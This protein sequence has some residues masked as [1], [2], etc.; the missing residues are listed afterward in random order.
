MSARASHLQLLA[1]YRCDRERA[2]ENLA[3]PGTSY[4]V[5]CH[6]NHRGPY[7]GA[8]SLLRQLVPEVY[9]RYPEHVQEHSI[10]ILSLAPELKSLIPATSETLTSLAVPEERTRFYS[11]YRTL[12]LTHGLIDFLKGCLRLGIYDHLSLYFDNLQ[13]ADQLD[14]EFLKELLRRADPLTL[15]VVVGTSTEALPEPFATVLTTY[16][17][18][19]SV[20]P[21]DR[22]S[23]TRKLQADG[24]PQVWQ[25]WLLQHSRGYLGE[26]EAAKT[27]LDLLPDS[28]PAGETF[29]EGIRSL[30]VQASDEQRTCWSQA[31]IASN[32][33]SDV[34]LERLAYELAADP[35]RRRWHD[36]RAEIL[37][38]QDDWSLRLGA[39]PYQREHGTSPQ[40]KGAEAL[41]LA[42][43][44][45]LNMGYYEATI[46][47]G[48]RGRAVI[49]WQAQFQ[50]YWTFTTKSTTSLAALERPEEAEE[51]YEE[52]RAQSAEP[53]VHMNAAYAL[54]MF[55]TRH[56]TENKRD[57]IL[58]KAWINEAI[59]IAS[60]LPDPKDSAFHV[61][62][63]QNGLALIENHLRR[64][65]EALRLVSEGMERL[66]RVLST[67]EH[68]LHRSVLL[69]NRAQVYAAMGKLDQ[70][71]ADYTAV[72]E[73][74][75]RYSEYYFDRGNILRRL[76]R[77][78]EALADYQL[79]IRYSPPYPEA[80]YNRACLLSVLGYEEE[81]LADYSYVIEIEPT[82]L[83][84]LINRA[85]ML[86]ERGLYAEARQDIANGLEL[87]PENAQLLCTLGL[88]E[89]AEEQY[90][91]ALQALSQ[92][93]VS[94]PSLI[95]AWTNR[96]ILTFERGDT[97][98]AI[99]DLTSALA[100]EENATVFYNRGIA[101]QAQ[102]CWQKAIDDFTQALALSDED[103]QDIFYRRSLCYQQQ[104]NEVQAQQDLRQHLAFGTSHYAESLN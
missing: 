3:L 18:K 6:R 39:I 66:N 81:A 56:H 54:A 24:F 35:T 103:A 52:V 80:Y 64:P 62:F 82:N 19:V 47:L 48:F 91:Q 32:G 41:T 63:Y 95:A 16:V 38:Q 28:S 94:D 1:P 89:M 53:R 2:W 92:A 61:V 44:Y 55:Y 65:E 88:I 104:G 67:D 29:E 4:R 30:V 49:D 9:A 40:E 57:H 102:E 36:E 5:D 34:L 76:G 78:E 69:Y 8:G 45:C 13:A 26:Y 60:L 68:M 87:S 96:A 77:E 20:E 74:D 73:K 15:Q 75:P 21:P 10:E 99:A 25:E 11:R 70:A 97:E 90:S 14:Q 50:D 79:A 71:L 17:R 42:L 101:Y 23:Y 51:I 100:L 84:A 27:L 7:T 33:S 58:A 43:N 98:A 37:A 86:Y 22:E 93:I 59:A 83:D 72:I 46:D 85:S 12:R 31:F